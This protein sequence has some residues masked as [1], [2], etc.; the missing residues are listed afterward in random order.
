MNPWAMHRDPR[1]WDDPEKFD[2]DRWQNGLAARLPRFTFF[3][4]SSGPRRC[5]DSPA[6]SIGTRLIPWPGCMRRE[7]RQNGLA[8]S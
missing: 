6:L 1:F 3:P 5:A 4:F 7:A 2:P 8:R